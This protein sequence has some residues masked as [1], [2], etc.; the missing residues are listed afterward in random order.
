MWNCVKFMNVAWNSMK[1]EL[2]YKKNGKEKRGALG[3][4][5]A[6]HWG[7][8]LGKKDYVFCKIIIVYVVLHVN[9]CV[10]NDW[11]WKEWGNSCFSKANFRP[12]ACVAE[13]NNLTYSSLDFRREFEWEKKGI[14]IGFICRSCSY[15]CLLSK[16]TCFI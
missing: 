7:Q 14:R 12:N 3:K 10:M 15:G 5:M 9:G 13:V 8:K 4:A 1:W 6:G 2:I 11:A 16:E